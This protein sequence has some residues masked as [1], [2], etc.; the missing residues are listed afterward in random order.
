MDKDKRW[1]KVNDDAFEREDA[2]HFAE[3]IRNHWQRDRD[4]R[5][6]GLPRVIYAETIH[7]VQVRAIPGCYGKQFDVY[8]SIPA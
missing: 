7:D 6:I 5:I 4:G 8:V 2:E 3:A 1:C